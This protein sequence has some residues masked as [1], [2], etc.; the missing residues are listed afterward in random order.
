[1]AVVGQVQWRLAPGPWRQR[2]HHGHWRAHRAREDGAA[3]HSSHSARSLG[4]AA[5]VAKSLAIGRTLSRQ[6]LSVNLRLSWSSPERVGPMRTKW[7]SAYDSGNAV[8]ERFPRAGRAPNWA[9]PS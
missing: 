8:P 9:W 3:T 6:E 7:V 5:G 1:M 4:A 2:R